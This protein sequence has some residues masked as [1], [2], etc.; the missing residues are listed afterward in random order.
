MM[1]SRIWNSFF[2]S[3]TSRVPVKGSVPTEPERPLLGPDDTLTTTQPMPPSPTIARKVYGAAAQY[4]DS[5]GYRTE[6]KE[7]SDLHPSTVRLLD[8]GRSVQGRVL[9][10]MS[11]GHG[12]VGVVLTG[13]LHA[14]EWA[15]AQPTLEAVR[16]VLGSRPDL[17]EKLTI[18]VVPVGNPDGYELSRLAMP[19][20]RGNLHAVDLNRNFPANWG[21]GEGGRAA[22]C[23]EFGGIG[24]KPL[25]EPE[26]QAL[27]GL[28]DNQPGIEG[29]MDFHSYGEMYLHPRSERQGE[30]QALIS[31]LQQA[32]PFEA[33]IIQDFQPINGSLADYCES[34]GVLGVGVELGTKFKPVNEEREQT[35]A[36]GHDIAMAFLDHMADR[37]P[38]SPAEPA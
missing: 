20:Q 6:M 31:D 34:R 10:G 3:Q 25:S 38:T 14:S 30:Y 1:I 22:R 28:L 2:P 8:L 24:E 17:L 12:P 36:M 29:W 26:S 33:K 32:A 15:T 18:H 11:V 9:Q 27:A 4:P 16:T 23:D 7:L 37:G 19:G 5:E 35:I 21:P 13:M